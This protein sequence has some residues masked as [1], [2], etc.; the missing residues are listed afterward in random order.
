LSWGEW[1]RLAATFFNLRDCQSV[2]GGRRC[3]YVRWVL[4][5]LH[6]R[7]SNTKSCQGLLGIEVQVCNGNIG[8]GGISDIDCVRGSELLL[9]A[10]TLSIMRVMGRGS[11]VRIPVVILYGSGGWD[12]Y[13]GMRIRLDIIVP[14]RVICSGIKEGLG[15]LKMGDWLFSVGRMRPRISRWPG[16]VVVHGVV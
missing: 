1:Y 12:N 16:A 10:R 2:G 13:G 3:T 5:S 11:G 4:I 9:E 15:K 7:E 14:K 8:L 6:M